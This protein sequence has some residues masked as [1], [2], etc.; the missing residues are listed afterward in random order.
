MAPLALPPV[1]LSSGEPGG[2]YYL[3]PSLIEGLVSSV[4]GTIVECNTAYG[5]GRST[6]EAHYQVAADHGFTCI[7]DFRIM[8]E[9]GSLSL[10]VDG[11]FHLSENLVGAAFSDYDAFL[12]LSH[13]KGHTMVGF[14]GALKNIAIGN[15]AHVL[16]AAE[17]LG[18]GSLIRDV[19]DLIRRMIEKNSPRNG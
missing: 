10:P 6:T 7:A 18:G 12:V 5:G 8:D 9:A 14:G 11:G 2:N 3:Q 17:S 16:E 1:K 13:F 15:G 4:F 19:I